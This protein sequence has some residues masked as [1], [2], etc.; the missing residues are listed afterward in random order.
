M[1]LFSDPNSNL[2]QDPF[3]YTHLPPAGVEQKKPEQD[4]AQFSPAAA[5]PPLKQLEANQALAAASEADLTN[6]EV[7]LAAAASAANVAITHLRFKSKAQAQQPQ[8]PLGQGGQLQANVSD[9]LNLAA[10]GATL[11]KNAK[12]LGIHMDDWAA[13]P[14]SLKEFELRYIEALLNT[15]TKG[16]TSNAVKNML[17]PGG[18][19]TFRD[20]LTLFYR[21][22]VIGFQANQPLTYRE[23][24]TSLD[25][26][27]KGSRGTSYE[28]AVKVAKEVAK[29]ILPIGVKPSGVESNEG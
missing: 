7:K 8:S 27:L 12:E 13:F 26:L 19:G 20:V 2:S 10:K 21:D 29:E 4:S 14:P 3:G 9:L 6:H 16:G 11:E 1:N 22:C 23:F 28:L 5:A 18:G 15:P 17:T 25:S 24:E